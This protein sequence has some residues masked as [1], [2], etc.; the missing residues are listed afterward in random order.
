MNGNYCAESKS[1]EVLVDEIRQNAKNELFP[2]KM[3]HTNYL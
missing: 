2:H 3:S 1:V